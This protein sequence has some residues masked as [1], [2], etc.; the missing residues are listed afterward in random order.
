[1]VHA[2]NIAI[3]CFEL[4]P[5]FF[6]YGKEFREIETQNNIQQIINLQQLVIDK[7]FEDKSASISNHFS[8]PRCKKLM[9]KGKMKQIFET[10][11]KNHTEFSGIVFVNKQGVSEIDTSGL[12]VLS[13]HPDCLYFQEA[14]KGN[15]YV[16]ERAHRKTVN[17][18]TL[19]FFLP[20][21]LMMS[22]DFKGLAIRTS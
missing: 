13:L 17:I 5:P 15:S 10:F 21:S 3:C 20:Q 14:K 16:T 2:F 4:S 6:P 7:W 1:M 22:N 19:S 12:P 9:E 11:D 18:K 8:T